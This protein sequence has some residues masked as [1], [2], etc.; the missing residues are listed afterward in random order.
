MND[1]ILFTMHRPSNVDNLDKL[2]NIMNQ[3]MSISKKHKYFFIMHPR[4]FNQIKNHN[5]LKKIKMSTKYSPLNSGPLGYF[6]FMKVQKNAKLIV[7]D[8]GNSGRIN[9]F[10]SMPDSQRKYR[11]TNNN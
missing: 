3:I 6:D 8:S 4:T 11:K 7:T 1:Y 10:C 5:I 9:L 2:S